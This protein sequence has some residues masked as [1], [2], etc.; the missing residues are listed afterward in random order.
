[1]LEA[2]GMAIYRLLTSKTDEAEVFVYIW[3]SIF[4]FHIKTV[5][6]LLLLIFVQAKMLLEQDTSERYSLPEVSGDGPLE[7]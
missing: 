7:L 5:Q 3:L 4:W 2:R 1:M 6:L